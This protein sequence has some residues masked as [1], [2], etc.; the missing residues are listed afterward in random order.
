MKVK[1]LIGFQD[2]ANDK[3]TILKLCSD[4]GQLNIT[5]KVLNSLYNNPTLARQLIEEGTNSTENG[6]ID[7]SSTVDIDGYTWGVVGMNMGVGFEILNSSSEFLEQFSNSW[8]QYLYM[9]SE[10]GNQWFIASR[11]NQVWRSLASEL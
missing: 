5:G 4:T 11:D 9:F 3:V 1:T 8:Y 6:R 10:V 7:V 2:A